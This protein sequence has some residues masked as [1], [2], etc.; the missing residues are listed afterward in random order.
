MKKIKL[1]TE[2]SCGLGLI[3]GSISAM[4]FEWVATPLG[5]KDSAQ[6]PYKPGQVEV[7]D[8]GFI[9]PVTGGDI[10]GEKLGCTYLHLKKP[11]RGDF[12]IICT[13]Q[14]HTTEPATAWSIAANNLPVLFPVDG[15]SHTSALV[16]DSGAP[17]L[18]GTG[19]DTLSEWAN[20]A[21]ATPDVQSLRLA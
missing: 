12:A 3:L 21:E 11:V 10:W 1:L 4:A 9:T 19:L 18:P 16:S 7:L 2:I 15:V 17:R 20:G 13:I 6:G 5:G 8:N 14:E